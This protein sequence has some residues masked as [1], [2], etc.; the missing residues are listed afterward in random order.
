MLLIRLRIVQFALLV[1]TA[2][3]GLID[4]QIAQL[5]PL[6][7][8][9]FQVAKTVQLAGLVKPLLHNVWNAQLGLSVTKEKA[10]ALLVLRAVEAIV[11]HPTASFALLAASSSC[12]T[13]P[14]SC[15]QRG[16]PVKRDPQN[17][18]F[19][20]P[21]R[22]VVKDLQAALFVLLVLGLDVPVV[23]ALLVNLVVG[24]ALQQVD[25]QSVK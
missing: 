1:P 12:P 8:L 5:E 9:A 4:A 16:G 24:V 25:A 2:L 14:A 3:E 17:A 23:T 20:L 22:L 11:G 18:R 10:A 6:A 15:A 21:E 7:L 13:T 19:A